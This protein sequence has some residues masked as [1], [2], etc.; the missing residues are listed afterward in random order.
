[1]PCCG[2]P[3]FIS[4]SLPGQCGVNVRS[5]KGVN[6]GSSWEK[7]GAIMVPVLGHHRGHFRVIMG[8]LPGHHG[9]I[10]GSLFGLVGVTP[11]SM[12]SHHGKLYWVPSWPSPGRIPAS[13]DPFRDLWGPSRPVRILTPGCRALPRSLCWPSQFFIHGCMVRLSLIHI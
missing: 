13:L 6:L 9:V 7:F 11:G 2:H 3:G 12:S 8:S 10:L 4:G 5:S 1:M